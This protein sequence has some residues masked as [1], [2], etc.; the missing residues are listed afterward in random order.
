M[1]HVMP[2]DS[3]SVPKRTLTQSLFVVFLRLVAVVCLWLGLQYWAMLVGYSS[4]G[5]GRFD[6]LSLPWQVAASSLAVLLPIVSL[7]LWLTVSWGPVLWVCA[8]TTQLL[9][10]TM[11]PQNFGTN[12]SVLIFH[13]VVASLYILFRI[14]LWLEERRKAEQVTSDLP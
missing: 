8:A 13:A 6:L 5:S 9:M 10:Y 11:W 12:D 2:H 4:G 7:G 1:I 14:A 3:H